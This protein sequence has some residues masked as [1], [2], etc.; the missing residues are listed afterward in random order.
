MTVP[1][2]LNTARTLGY[3]T[4]LQAVTANNLANASTDGF[5]AE[6]VSAQSFAEAF[7][8][9]LASIDMRQGTVRDTGRT[10]D[11]ALE[12]DAFFVVRTPQG[13]RLTRNGGFSMDTNGF[14]IN[15]DGDLVLGEEGPLHVRGHEVVVEDDGTVVV[16]GARA[17]RLRLETVSDLGTLRKEGHGRLVATTPLAPVRNATVRQG[18]LEDANVDPLLGTVDLIQIQRAYAA[19]VEAMRAMDGVMSAVA[20][21]IGRVP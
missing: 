17:D 18:A 2:I 14:L 16:D 15:H 5:K 1:G 7:P 9:A 20:R 6:R 21:D 8:E 3:Y 19:N 11:L 12:G 4:R 13:E 10:F